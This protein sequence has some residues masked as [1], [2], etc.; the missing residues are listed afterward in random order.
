VTPTIAEVDGGDSTGGECLVLIIFYNFFI[1]TGDKK[2]N[3]SGYDF[4]NTGGNMHSIREE[5]KVSI[6]NK[7]NKE[8]PR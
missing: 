2:E 4:V 1:L 7:D 5:G 8:T 3:Y 6:S